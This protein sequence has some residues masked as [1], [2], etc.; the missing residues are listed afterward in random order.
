MTE[1]LLNFTPPAFVY[2]SNLLLTTVKVLN[3]RFWYLTTLFSCWF[4]QMKTN[5]FACFAFHPKRPC[6]LYVL[7]F[8]ECIHPLSVV[9]E[10][11]CVR[12]YMARMPSA[13][14]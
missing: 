6:D 7:T 11:E 9:K 4:I 13:L 5:C 3:L 8:T 2:Q 1:L 12:S 10:A 14:R